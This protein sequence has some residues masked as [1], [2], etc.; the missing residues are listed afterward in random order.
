MRKE[1]W[2]P[3]KFWDRQCEGV[4]KASVFHLT[5]LNENKRFWEYLVAN[6]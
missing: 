3:Q 6:V 4:E 5:L 1:L 2:K